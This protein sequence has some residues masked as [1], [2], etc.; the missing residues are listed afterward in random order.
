M[1]WTNARRPPWLPRDVLLCLANG[2]DKVM[3]F[4]RTGFDPDRWGSAAG[5]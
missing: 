2:M 4:S 3:V 1:A 5:C